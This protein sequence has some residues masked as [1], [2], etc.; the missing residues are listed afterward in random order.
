MK[1]KNWEDT[2]R[3]FIEWLSNNDLK[4]E[5]SKSLCY[6]NLSLW[7]LT[8]LYEKDNINSQLWYKNLNKTF[9]GK[10][11][12]IRKNNIYLVIG[13]LKLIKKFLSSIFLNIFIKIFYVEKK[14]LK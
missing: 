3:A 5:F 7:W 2:R 12:Q 14:S 11:N 4:N 9:L 13:I 8:T 1:K 10:K 6:K